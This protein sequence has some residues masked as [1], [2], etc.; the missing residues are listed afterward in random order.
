MRRRLRIKLLLRMVRIAQIHGQL[1]LDPFTVIVVLCETP[2]YTV[3]KW[4]F[5]KYHAAIGKMP[6]VTWYSIFCTGTL[7]ELVIDHVQTGIHE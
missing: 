3:Q 5:T 4:Y 6:V 1:Y 7:R 2:G